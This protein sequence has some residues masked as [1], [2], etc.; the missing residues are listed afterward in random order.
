M[1]QGP[2][3][4]DT[5]RGVRARMEEVSGGS[6]G[7]SRPSLGSRGGQGGFSRERDVQ[8]ETHKKVAKRKRRK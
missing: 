1:S 4:G 3:W 8:F 7:G 2:D 6:R 5:G